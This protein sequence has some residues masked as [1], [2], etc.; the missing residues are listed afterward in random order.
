M[1]TDETGGP[2]PPQAATKADPY[3]TIWRAI[4]NGELAPG[5]ALT[6]VALAKW[7][8]V[9][10]TPIREALS[11]LVS[12]GLVER[13]SRG[14]M[15]RQRTIEEIFNI[16][17]V[18]I[19]LESTAARAAAERRTDLD[20]TMLR[21]ALERY[22]EMDV[23]VSPAVVSGARK[24]HEA[25]WTV[26]RNETLTDTL[27]RLDMLVPRFPN[28]AMAD[29]EQRSRTA[30]QHRALFDAIE[31]RDGDAAAEAARTHYIEARDIRLRTFS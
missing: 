18:R 11:R 2:R 19:V 4:R 1:S 6:E 17:E 21:A 26:A 13:T 27:A 28:T 9:S 16:Y 14:P 22:E 31:A 23:E 29:K 7:C 15:V 20:L 8:G 30:T 3:E 25:V 10:R 12:E 5:Q 24:F